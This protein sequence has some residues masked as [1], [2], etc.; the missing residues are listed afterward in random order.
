MCQTRRW[1]GDCRGNGMGLGTYRRK[2]SFS[3]TPEPAGAV[4]GSASGR[5]F[6]VQKHAASS[7]HYDFR[8]E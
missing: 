3:E 7:L 1:H 2:R 6:V 8:L 4:G 5:S